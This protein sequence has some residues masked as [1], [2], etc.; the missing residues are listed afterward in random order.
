MNERDRGFISG[1][2]G[3]YAPM[4]FVLGYVGSPVFQLAGV[5]ML[6][7]SFWLYAIERVEP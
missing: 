4:A 5:V 6:G 7:V 3:G 2:L 1:L